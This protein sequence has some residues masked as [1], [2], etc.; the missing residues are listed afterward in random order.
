MIT[1]II[2]S[3]DRALQLDLTL[4]SIKQ[5]FPQSNNLMVI[6]TVSEEHAKSYELL[7]SEHEGV[8]FYKQTT[9]LFLDISKAVDE[10]QEYVCFFTDDDI[11]YSKVTLNKEN[12]C[13]LFKSGAACLSLRLG[14]NTNMRDYGDGILREDPFPRIESM[15]P[16]LVWNRTSIPVGGYWSYPLSVDGHIFEKRTIQLFCKELAV[17]DKH[18]SYQGVRREKY[19][20]QQTPNEFE[21]KL[22]RF[23]FDLPPIMGAFKASSVVNSPNN[24][25]QESTLNRHGDVYSLDQ[26]TLLEKYTNGHRIKLENLKI[27]NIKCPHTEI[28]ILKGLQ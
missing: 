14:L 9:S 16:F 5:N 6:Y 15:D 11:V 26:N 8:T 4:K 2:F 10:S 28:D 12:L 17:L 19:C 22:Q 24:R 25:V 27:N 18:Y 7:A 21:S 3:K 13:N 23:W 1:S 20:W